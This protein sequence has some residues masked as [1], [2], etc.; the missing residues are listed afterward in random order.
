MSEKPLGLLWSREM[1]SDQA[2]RLHSV[3]GQR[4][5]FIPLPQYGGIA[6]Q[7][8][9]TSSSS[10]FEPFGVG[11]VLSSLLPIEFANRHDGPARGPQGGRND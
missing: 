7:N 9:P 10:Q 4:L 2:E 8:R 1:S 3:D 11:N 5:E 6:E